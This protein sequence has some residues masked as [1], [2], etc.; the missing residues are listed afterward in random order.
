MS[1]TL[2]SQHPRKSL[3]S[4]YDVPY[5]LHMLTGAIGY[6]GYGLVLVLNLRSH[7]NL[8]F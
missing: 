6:H 1:Y 4:E 7:S 3:L 2:R 5:K 8:Y